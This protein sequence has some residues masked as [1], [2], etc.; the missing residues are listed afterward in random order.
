MPQVNSKFRSLIVQRLCNGVKGTVLIIY[1]V[2]ALTICIYD[3]L[4]VFADE[5]ELVGTSRWSLGKGLYYFVSSS[6]ICYP[7]RSH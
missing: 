1:S 4:I 7:L 3:W 2:I 5:V 6:R